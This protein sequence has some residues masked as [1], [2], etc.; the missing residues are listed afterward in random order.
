MNKNKRISIC[1]ILLV[2][3][4]N[5]LF[6]ISY[7]I[8]D[9]SIKDE[10]IAPNLISANSNTDIDI[11]VMCEHSILVEPS[12]D[13]ILYEHDAYEKAYPASV[14][15]ILCALVALENSKLTDTTKVSQNAIKLIPNGYSTANLAVDEEVTME[16][17]LEALL[18]HSANEAANVISEAISGS[19]EAYA[20]KMN[21]RA[22]ELGCK[23]THFVNGNGI[24]S[25]DH[26]TTAYDM[27]LIAKECMKNNDFR[28]IVQ[29]KEV[30][31]PSSPQHPA[32][33]RVFKNTDQLL[34][35]ENKYYYEG[36]LGIKTGF[37]TQAKNCFIGAAKRNDFELI[38]VVLGA[39]T[40]NSESQRFPDTI[41]LFNYG[42]DNYKFDKIKNDKD[43]LK[44]V[45]IENANDET[46]SLNLLLEKG[47]DAFINND[48]DIEKLEP[49]LEYTR[50]LKAPIS[51]GEVLGTATYTIG[52]QT[53]TSNIL[54]GS[55]VVAK[56]H[57]EIYL[58]VG[59]G[60]LLVIGLLILPKKNKK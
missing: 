38:S 42:F 7:A 44:T 18:I 13:T 46:K 37:T 34:L 17:L 55:D 3:L 27:Y 56:I 41:R 51:M 14:T 45:E 35:P 23:N 54:A 32:E 30:S 12:T 5:I 57:Y 11:G 39:P 9:N 50:E 16:T 25:E 21:K 10:N 20:D 43:I 52:T 19:V 6:N 2:F 48:F 36:T 4:I 49:Q 24:H 59:G 26:Y 33:D 28:R 29:M 1:G 8:P 47:F 53:F 15:K 60:V 22:L 31:I 40:I 58:M